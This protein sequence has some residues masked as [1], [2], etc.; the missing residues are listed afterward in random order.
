MMLLKEVCAVAVGVGD[1]QNIVATEVCKR[2]MGTMGVAVMG[3][4]M[5]VGCDR[6]WVMCM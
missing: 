4:V 3:T 1:R 6:R 5:S 2:L